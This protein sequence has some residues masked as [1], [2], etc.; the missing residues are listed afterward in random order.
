VKETVAQINSAGGGRAIG[1][2]CDAAQEDQV[3]RM[4]ADGVRAFRKIDTLVD[5]AGDG[6]LSWP[7]CQRGISCLEHPRGEVRLYCE[8][9][10][11]SRS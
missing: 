11:D 4:I 1:V 9:L 3:R 10:A 5:N 7:A 2:V 6:G 8:C